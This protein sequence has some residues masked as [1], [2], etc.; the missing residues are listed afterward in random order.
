MKNNISYE[1]LLQLAAR[2]AFQRKMSE[3]PSDRELK[4]LYGKQSAQHKKRMQK[5]LARENRKNTVYDMARRFSKIYLVFTLTFVLFSAALLSAEAVRESI[6]TT[7]FDWQTGFTNI[8]VHGELSRQELPDID[9]AYIPPGFSLVSDI[10][11]SE[12]SR[13]I[14]F[15][16]SS[17]GH[18]TIHL[19]T[20]SRNFSANADNE[21]SDYY[22]LT[23]DNVPGT[24]I[25]QGNINM[26]IISADGIFCN[27]SGTVPVDEI[28]RIYKNLK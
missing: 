20:F 13:I 17:A 19:T 4:K 11:V 14:E 16:N 2:E 18:I 5:L 12:D 10:A 22:K 3:I 6:A 8:F 27:I 15:E 26:L 9:A 23:I 21:Y 28:I 24:W 1:N 7:L 25:Q